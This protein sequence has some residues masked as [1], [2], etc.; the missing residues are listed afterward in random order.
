MQAE[1]PG[2]P[3]KYALTRIAAGDYLM[4]SN[5]ARAIWR[6]S[7]YEDGPSHGLDQP[8]DFKVWGLWRWVDQIDAASA[9]D[10]QD[11][12]RWEFHSGLYETRQKAIH[13]ALKMAA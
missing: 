6:I 1:S 9:V 3:R 11:W 10:V 4:P 7:R 2:L 12:S 5:S 8:R 13:A